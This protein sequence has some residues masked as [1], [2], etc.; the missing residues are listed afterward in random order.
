V[1]SGTCHFKQVAQLPVSIYSPAFQYWVMQSGLVCI[2]YRATVAVWDPQRQE[3]GRCRH[4]SSG[5]SGSCSGWDPPHSHGKLNWLA[6][7][8]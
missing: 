8:S 5:I 1:S 4:L 3:L 7:W 6:M 2:S